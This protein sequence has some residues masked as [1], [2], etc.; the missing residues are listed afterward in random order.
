MPLFQQMYSQVERVKETPL[1]KSVTE[2]AGKVRQRVSNMKED[3]Q[4]RWETSDSAVVH[5][6]QV[7]GGA[8]I[9]FP[10]VR[11]LFSQ[12]SLN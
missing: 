11:P 12:R 6:I 8:S 3:L 4:E 9:V 10:S 2:Q 5:G 7:R 1:A